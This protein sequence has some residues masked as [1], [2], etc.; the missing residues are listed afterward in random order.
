MSKSVVETVYGKHHKYEVIQETSTFASPQY[1]V[2]RSDGKTSG[3]FSSLAD[4]V[5]WAQSQG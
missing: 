3:M 2:R 5:E 1:Y 4:A